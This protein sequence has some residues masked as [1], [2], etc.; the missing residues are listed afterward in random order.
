MRPLLPPCKRSLGQ[1]AAPPASEAPLPK[2]TVK[3]ISHSIV[4]A[5]DGLFRNGGHR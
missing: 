4:V 1:F 2:G 3:A 5:V